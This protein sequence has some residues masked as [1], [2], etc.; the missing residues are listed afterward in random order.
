VSWGGNGDASQY[1]V[2]EI[3]KIFAV[4]TVKLMEEFAN[5]KIT[6]KKKKTQSRNLPS[7]NRPSDRMHYRKT[8]VQITRQFIQFLKKIRVCLT[9]YTFQNNKNR[10]LPR[11]GGWAHQRPAGEKTNC[12]GIRMDWRGV[13][14]RW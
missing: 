2:F 5:D 11:R 7:S 8:E 14:L 10:L 6:S 3:T 9:N 12:S 1:W 4:N 13:S